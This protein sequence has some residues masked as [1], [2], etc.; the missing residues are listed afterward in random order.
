MHWPELRFLYEV[1][2]KLWELWHTY[3]CGSCRAERKRGGE[4]AR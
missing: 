4:G 2:W 1:H 3:I